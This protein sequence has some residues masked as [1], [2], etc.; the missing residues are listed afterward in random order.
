[1]L[2][3]EEERICLIER[4]WEDEELLLVVNPSVSSM[5][6][7]P[8][9]YAPGYDTLAAYLCTDPESAV[10]YRPEGTGLRMP[11]RS[12]AVLTKD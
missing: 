8:E 5:Q 7:S 11:P 1:M 9:H 4:R 6:L 12:I 10:I 3:C 2:P